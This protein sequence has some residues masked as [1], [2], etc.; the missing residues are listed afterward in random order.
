MPLPE[1][2]PLLLACKPRKGLQAPFL[3]LVTEVI[4]AQRCFSYLFL[5][6]SH[7]FL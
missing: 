7:S 4:K 5:E 2:A 1:G 3:D 6:Q